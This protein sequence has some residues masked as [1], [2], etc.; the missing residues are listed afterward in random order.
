MA[1]K[2]RSEVRGRLLR[3][4]DP[5]VHDP[6]VCQDE[7]VSGMTLL[8]FVQVDMRL[9]VACAVDV[10]LSHEGSEAVGPPVADNDTGGVLV[11]RF[12][13]AQRKLDTGQIHKKEG[14]VGILKEGFLKETL[15]LGLFPRLPE[16]H[17]Q[18][19]HEGTV[20]G[21]FGKRLSIETKGRSKI[22]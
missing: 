18:I 20:S 19:V 12:G 21:R 11:G 22:P 2:G 5:V 10:D 15:R 6:K 4:S 14:V 17:R 1:G 8:G 9:L 13:M 16:N 3:L 7:R